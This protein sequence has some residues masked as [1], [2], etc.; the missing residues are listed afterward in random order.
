MNEKSDSS[1]AT[2]GDIAVYQAQRAHEL[3]LNK[4]TAT[5][6]HAVASAL[7]LLNGGAAVAFLT[8]IGASAKNA[9]L[10]LDLGFAVNALICWAAALLLAA[11]GVYAGY[12]SQQQFTRAVSCRRQL[13]E[14]A[15]IDETSRLKGVLRAT[16]D[17]TPESL[18]QRARTSQIFWLS[19]SA[20]AIALFVVGVGLAAASV[21]SIP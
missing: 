6:E 5:F 12:R 4:A 16:S 13:M 18:Y 14:H 21:L 15:L 7:F 8:L 11:A 2:N 1:V 3:E 17:E 20:L 9:T 19:F 10:S